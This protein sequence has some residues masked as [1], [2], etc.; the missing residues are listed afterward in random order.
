MICEAVKVARPYLSMFAITTVR[1]VGWRLGGEWRER[2]EILNL[3]GL[4]WGPEF[5]NAQLG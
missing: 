1:L 2:H 4:V 5:V 3:D